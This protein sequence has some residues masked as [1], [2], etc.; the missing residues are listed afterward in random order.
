MKHNYLYKC[1]AVAECS[2]WYHHPIFHMG[3]VRHINCDMQ[4]GKY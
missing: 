4:V 1:S 2:F 3:D